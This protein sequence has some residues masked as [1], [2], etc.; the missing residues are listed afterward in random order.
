M[1]KRLNTLNEEMDRIKSLF[2]EERM[3]GN[4]V[5]QELSD[6]DKEEIEA[7]IEQDAQTKSN[8]KPTP[9][10]GQV[11]NK[12]TK[13]IDKVGEKL[14]N[15]NPEGKRG[16]Q[17]TEAKGKQLGGDNFDKQKMKSSL[18]DQGL[19]GVSLDKID[20]INNKGACRRHLKNM[21][22]ISKKGMSRE[23]FD[24]KD[25]QM[26]KEEMVGPQ[27]IEKVEWC[28][29]NFYN[30]F[31]KEGFLKKGSNVRKMMDTLKI[32]MSDQMMKKM[33]DEQ[34]VD[35]EGVYDDK[36]AYGGLKG[37][38]YDVLDDN[39]NKVGVIKK[40]TENKYRFRSSK[41]HAI[42]DDSDKGNPKF[43]DR[44]VKFFYRAINIDPNKHRIKI[45]NAFDK[46][47]L[48]M[49]TFVLVKK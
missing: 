43:R 7:G 40:T 20:I 14:R 41:G 44:Y 38:R 36:K 34:Q 11:D 39:D 4:L 32:P 6:K 37:Q 48:D 1:K 5:E 12:V 31:E 18:K 13:A 47:K 30:S 27:Y 16:G 17:G 46:N 29:R 9:K 8:E 3:F 10:V 23:D 42:L 49:G 21:I 45:Q 35:S 26:N 25:N 22:T 24:D 15:T 19:F 2:S 33:G 28:V